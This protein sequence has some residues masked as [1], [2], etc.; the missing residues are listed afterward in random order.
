[1][2][3]TTSLVVAGPNDLV[4]TGAPLAIDG[5]SLVRL[6]LAK[7]EENE[8]LN[9]ARA[10]PDLITSFTDALL[11]I[12]S[13]QTLREHHCGKHHPLAVW[14][15]KKSGAYSRQTQAPQSGTGQG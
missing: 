12:G 3:C 6:V 11:G 14:D 5:V 2:V 10:D 1:M 13:R 15:L 8:L 4:H 9:E 7:A